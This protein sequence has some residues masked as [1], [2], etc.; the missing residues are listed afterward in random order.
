MC[1]VIAGSLSASPALSRIT[2]VKRCV[3]DL[4]ARRIYDQ[5]LE[6]VHSNSRQHPVKIAVTLFRQAA[7]GKACFAYIHFR[8]ITAL[9]REH[10]GCEGC[11]SI[12]PPCSLIHNNKLELCGGYSGD[13]ERLPVRR[14]YSLR[15]KRFGIYAC[16]C[17]VRFLAIPNFLPG[18]FRPV[19]AV[20]H[21]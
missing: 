12:I 1:I 8:I 2:T 21:Y 19:S 18:K 13:S 5:Q 6:Q 4:Y 7:Q 16:R 14:R 11:N 10:V 9:A 3:V 17:I 15:N 20:Q